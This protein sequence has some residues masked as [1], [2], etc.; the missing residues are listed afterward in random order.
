MVDRTEATGLL[1]KAAFKPEWA[2]AK[3]QEDGSFAPMDEMPLL[4]QRRT[5]SALEVID[6]I[7]ASLGEQRI[8]VEQYYAELGRAQQESSI[9]YADALRAADNHVI[10]RETVQNIAWQHGLVASFAPKPLAEQASNGNHIHFSACDPTGEQN[11]FF[12][13]QGRF[14]LSQTA[15]HFM[16]GVLE[17]FPG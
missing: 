7:V 10:Y 9:H 17:H 15:Y 4:Q 2:L 14:D 12:G 1:I 3:R 8:Q 13:A 11:L 6:D 5:I 16:G